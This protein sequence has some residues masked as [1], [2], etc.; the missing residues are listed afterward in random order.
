MDYSPLV[1]AFARHRLSHSTPGDAEVRKAGRFTIEDDTF[2][3]V[4]GL[5]SG[6]VYLW[7]TAPD[8]GEEAQIN[9]S[10]QGAARLAQELA[11]RIATPSGRAQGEWRPFIGQEVRATSHIIE[12][13]PDWRDTRLWVV[14]ISKDRIGNQYPVDGI[15]ITVSDEWPVTSKT[16][17][18]TDG[19]YIG[20]QYDADD[21][22]PAAPPAQDQT[23]GDEA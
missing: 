17:G 9:L 8:T 14:G 1:Q 19:F 4:R 21:L 7:Q 10:P 18:F 6:H 11:A 2:V 12:K 5:V 20:R 23:K 16:G 15:N 22:E 13:W 3:E